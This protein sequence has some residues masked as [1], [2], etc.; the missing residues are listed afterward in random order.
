MKKTIV[1]ALLLVGAPF[2]AAAQVAQTPETALAAAQAAG[3]CDGPVL[4]ARWE[5]GRVIATC[6]VVRLGGENSGAIAGAAAGVV[7]LAALAGG[8]GSSTT[9][10]TAADN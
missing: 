2:A 9:T 7:V 4:A 5:A 3:V 1:A 10:T 8:G 6:E